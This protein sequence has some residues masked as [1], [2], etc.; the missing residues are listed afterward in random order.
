[1][2]THSIAPLKGTPKFWAM[3]GRLIF[4]MEVSRV[5][6]KMPMATR[7]KIVHFPAVSSP[8]PLLSGAGCES[9]NVADC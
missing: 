3:S 2:T 1:M 9:A 6:I 8:A 5:A 7:K 4:T